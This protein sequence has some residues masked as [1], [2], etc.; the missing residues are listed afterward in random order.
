M[1]G[2]ALRLLAR[3]LEIAQVE[4]LR[5][6]EELRRQAAEVNGTARAIELQRAV[7]I[8]ALA[9]SE[10]LAHT[11]APRL[12][13]PDSPWAGL[14]VGWDQGMV[15]M[16]AGMPNEGKIA[17][18]ALGAAGEYFA[19]VALNIP[20]AGVAR[21][22]GGVARAGYDAARVVAG[23][24]GGVL[25]GAGA[26]GVANLGAQAINKGVRFMNQENHASPTYGV[27]G[28]FQAAPSMYGQTST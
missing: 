16:D 20:G 13:L 3:R 11:D 10:P 25:A 19:K 1:P 24:P 27:P 6:E 7:I 21:A 9:M 15:R 26:L 23:L 12:L 4:A 17:A 5:R 8:R 14:P 28:G 2:S 22:V 18:E